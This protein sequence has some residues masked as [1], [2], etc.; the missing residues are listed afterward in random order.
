MKSSFLAASLLVF[1][2]LL[3]DVVAQTDQV[4]N[5]LELDLVSLYNPLGISFSAK[6]Y[7][8]QVYH[9]AASP[10]W[11]GLYYQAGVQANINPAFNRAGVHLEWM[12]IAVMQLRAQYDRLYFSGSH[13]SL[14]S[15]SSSND[16]FGDDELTAREG[17]AV[18]GEGQ[19][20][21]YNLTLRA[22]VG[23]AIFRNVTDIAQYEFPSGGPYYLEREY[24]I[25][26]AR[27]DQLLSNQFYL[28]Y[29]FKDE[30]NTTLFGPYHDVVKVRDSGLRR[31][32]LG[33]TL[34]REY[35]QPFG[36]LQKPRWY[37]QSGLYLQD[38]NREDE[39]YLLFGIGGDFNW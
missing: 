17:D 22:K 23:R 12:P 33:L 30:G 35:E 37:L 21:L 19:R 9:H 20:T 36:S 34:L 38:R 27:Q 26:M 28:L 13:G 15:F 18:S 5:R 16:R 29:E 6:G 31:E 10:L 4:V 14:L 2:L 24:E 3:R 25:L 7:R 1:F 39:F 11:D 32:R 8:R